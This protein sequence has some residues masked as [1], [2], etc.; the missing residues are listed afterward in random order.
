ML[1]LFYL[2][3]IISIYANNFYFILNF[4]EIFVT[5][6]KINWEYKSTC[7]LRCSIANYITQSPSIVWERGTNIQILST[8][9]ST[10]ELLI[11][12]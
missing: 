11:S 10:G 1:F 6:C 5:S 8:S 3:I 2:R 12:N 7:K 4:V 9:T